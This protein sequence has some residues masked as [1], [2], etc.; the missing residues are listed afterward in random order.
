[1]NFFT[2]TNTE[3]LFGGADKIALE[4]QRKILEKTGLTS[5]VGVGYSKMSAK[6]S[7]GVLPGKPIN[8]VI[9]NF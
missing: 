5:S 8:P 3:H 1:M 6:L 2:L 4:I 7:A 9:R